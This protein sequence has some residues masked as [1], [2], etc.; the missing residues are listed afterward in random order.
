MD[1]LERLQVPAK[2]AK[3]CAVEGRTFTRYADCY[4][5]DGVLTGGYH[6]VGPIPNISRCVRIEEEDYALACHRSCVE[7][8]RAA[9]LRDEE[10]RWKLFCPSK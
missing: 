7:V 9:Y 8:G 1:V 5:G 2:S 4:V 10:F 3:I 6:A